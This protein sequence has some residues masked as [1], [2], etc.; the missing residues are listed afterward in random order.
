MMTNI[1]KKKKYDYVCLK[2][3]NACIQ[4]ELFEEQHRDD[5]EVEHSPREAQAVPVISRSSLEW[6]NKNMKLTDRSHHHDL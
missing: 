3:N 2:K 6:E 1:D 4:G 5:E